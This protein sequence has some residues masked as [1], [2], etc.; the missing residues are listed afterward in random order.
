MKRTVL[1]HVYNE[2]YL[3]PFWIDHHR[4][5]FDHGV[6]VDWNSSD[7]SVEIVKEM[8]PEWEIVT[9]EHQEFDAGNCDLEM[10]KL[11]SK[12]PEGEWKITLNATEFIVGDFDKILPDLKEPTSHWLP[13]YSMVDERRFAGTY[14]DPNEL[15]I[16]QRHFGIDGRKIT[17]PLGSGGLEVSQAAYRRFRS[18][19][20]NDIVYPLGRHFDPGHER[21]ADQLF[22]LWYGYSPWNETIIKRKTQIKDKIPANNTALDLGFQ[23]LY[24]EEKLD[25]NHLMLL[26]H[27]L[28]DGVFACQDLSPVIQ[29]HIHYFK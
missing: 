24:T 10:A 26:E 25:S 3:L 4:R 13:C 16:E 23:H 1:T 6:V 5:V 8:A 22:V 19:H 9:S 17:S 2:E 20:N 7:H 11:E 29:K 15:L 14:P 28:E 21:L 12:I 18:I 27:H